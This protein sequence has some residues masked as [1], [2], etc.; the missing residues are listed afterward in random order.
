MLS[1]LART[2]CTDANSQMTMLTSLFLVIEKLCGVGDRVSVSTYPPDA[3]VI[4]ARRP[5]IS[6]SD[7]VQ[8]RYLRCYSVNMTCLGTKIEMMW[9]IRR[10]AL[11]SVTPH[12]GRGILRAERSSAAPHQLP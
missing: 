1:E 3:P 2:G 8:K 12:D 4:R 6:L 9:F 10:L 7:I 11:A 5:R